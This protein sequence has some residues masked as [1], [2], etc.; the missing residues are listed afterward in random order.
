MR[1]AFYAPMKP[2]T[3]D[4]PSGDRRMARLLIRALEFSGHDVHLACDFQSREP[5]GDPVRQQEIMGLGQSVAETLIAAYENGEAARPDAWFTYHLYYKAPDWIGPSVA[6]RLGI[7]YVVA[8][9]SHAPKR[10]GGPWD[11]NHRQAEAAIRRADRVFGLNTL[12]AGCIKPLLATPDK[13]VQMKPFLDLDDMPP[14]PDRRENSDKPV[15]LVAAAMMR[16]GDKLESYGVLAAALK[17]LPEDAWALEV[18]GDGPE[19]PSVEEMFAGLPVTFLGELSAKDL[20]AAFD[21]ADLFVWPAVNEAYGMALLEAQSRGLPVVAGRTHGV[22][23]IV[24]DGITGKLAAVGDADAFARA[25]RELIEQPDDLPKM[26]DAARQTVAAEH[27]LETAAAI[28]DRE[29]RA[30]AA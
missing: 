20:Y 21:R 13:L 11:L 16:S 14:V 1:I 6:N 18:A 9:A 10:A 19:R 27:S 17:R 2:P 4:V 12:D 5:A 7:P 3:S 23:D 24:R 25:V 8:E 29:I 15:R 30:V 26:S 22:P 28:L